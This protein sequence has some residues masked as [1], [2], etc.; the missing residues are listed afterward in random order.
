MTTSDLVTTVRHLVIRLR[1]GAH[2]SFGR[3]IRQHWRMNKAQTLV[4]RYTLNNLPGVVE[5]VRRG[6]RN[7]ER[8][9]PHAH[10]IDWRRVGRRAEH[11][12][13][14]AR[15]HLGRLTRGVRQPP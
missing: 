4:L 9:I 8:L 15:T 11:D 2:R 1:L 10:R 14:V 3:P 12:I 13:A 5:R 6:H 7:L